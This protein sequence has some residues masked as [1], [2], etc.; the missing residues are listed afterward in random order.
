MRKCTQSAKLHDIVQLSMWH[1]LCGIVYASK[2]LLFWDT[3]IEIGNEFEVMLQNFEKIWQQSLLVETN[4]NSGEFTTSTLQGSL[5]VT[6]SWTNMSQCF[7]EKCKDKCFMILYFIFSDRNGGEHMLDSNQIWQSEI[8][9]SENERVLYYWTR[10]LDYGT[11]NVIHYI[12]L[13]SR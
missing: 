10:K 2:A 9:M 8:I 5:Q 4:I 11:P 12:G 1:R 7:D 13:K 6:H 3:E